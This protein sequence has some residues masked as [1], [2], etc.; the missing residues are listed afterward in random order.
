MAGHKRAPGALA[1]RGGPSRARYMTGKVAVGVHGEVHRAIREA[2]RD[3]NTPGT[4][5]LEM[6][7]AVE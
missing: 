5:K 6:S 3:G 4:G 2:R 7:D 1:T